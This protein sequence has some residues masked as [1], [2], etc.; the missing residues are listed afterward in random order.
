[1]SKQEWKLGALQFYVDGKEPLAN[2]RRLEELLGRKAQEVWRRLDLLVLPELFT[3]GFNYDNNE[4]IAEQNQWALDYLSRISQ[5]NELIILGS[6]MESRLGERYN[7]QYL[8]LPGQKGRPFYRKT[9]LFFQFD[10]N[11]RFR[12]GDRGYMVEQD[13]LLFGGAVCYDLRFPPLFQGYTQAGASG[14]V[15]SAQ[16]PRKR[17]DHWQTLV[18][19]RGIENQL[20]LVACN[21]VS[22]SMGGH[23]LI[24]DWRGEILAEAG[25]AEGLITATINLQEQETWRNDFPVQ[26]DVRPIEDLRPRQDD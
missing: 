19:A 4:L 1:M 12:S 6:L 7:T 2:S 18:R 23:S 5:Q 26:G 14:V 22:H 3:S 10:E 8:W 16:W 9:H 20:W 15:L 25:D 17:V 11:R 24:V 21:A 13:G